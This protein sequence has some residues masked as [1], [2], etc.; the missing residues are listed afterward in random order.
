MASGGRIPGKRRIN[1]KRYANDL[2]RVG[3]PTTP[4]GLLSIKLERGGLPHS[5]TRPHFRPDSTC[6][7]QTDAL[8]WSNHWPS[9]PLRSVGHILPVASNSADLTESGSRS[10]SRCTQ[11]SRKKDGRQRPI[12]GP[13]GHRF[14]SGPLATGQKISNQ[15]NQPVR[16][17]LQWRSFVRFP[18]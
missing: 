11:Q 18:T 12:A 8:L 7:L 14:S 6:K 4:L 3:H 10:T 2:K 16:L 15:R 5:T 9:L 13:F 1:I 17:K